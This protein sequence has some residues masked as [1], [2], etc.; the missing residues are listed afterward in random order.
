[1]RDHRRVL[2]CHARDT[3]TW[4]KGMGDRWSVDGDE[5]VVA[6][7]AVGEG[8]TGRAGQCVGVAWVCLG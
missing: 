5:D 4:G 6:V 1:M 3:R 8:S 2:Q 7:G